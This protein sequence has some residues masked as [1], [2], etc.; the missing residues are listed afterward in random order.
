MGKLTISMAISIAISIIQ[1][2]YWSYVHQP[3]TVPGGTA[4]S[5][6]D[7]PRQP[8]MRNAGAVGW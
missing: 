8:K 7:I 4:Q 2:S 3:V 5:L 1:H 6:A